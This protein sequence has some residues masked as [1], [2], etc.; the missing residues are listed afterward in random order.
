MHKHVTYNRCHP[1]F[2]DFKAAVLTFPRIDTPKSWRTLGDKVSDSLRY[3]THQNYSA[4][5]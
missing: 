1:R 2:D 3:I 5:R 4:M